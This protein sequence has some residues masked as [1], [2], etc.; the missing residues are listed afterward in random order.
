MHPTPFSQRLPLG[1]EHWA[2]NVSG[3]VA[4]EVGTPSMQTILESAPHLKVHIRALLAPT[5][6]ARYQMGELQSESEAQARVQRPS[7]Q[8]LDSQS[9]WL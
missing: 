8:T 4:Q 1:H 9:S 3:R 6:Q 5:P 2:Q 7:M